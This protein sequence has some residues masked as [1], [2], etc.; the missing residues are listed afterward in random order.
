MSFR[1]TPIGSLKINSLIMIDDEPCKIVSTDKSKPGKH[2]SAKVRVVAIGV[3][4]SVKRSV[5][6]SVD[7]NVNSP[8]VGKKVAQVIS[9]SDTIQ[10]MDSETYEMFETEFPSDKELKNKIVEGADIE[11]WEIAGKTKLMRVR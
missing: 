5:V 3:F 10:L 2:G 11:Y 1:I 8:I 4:D 6:N 9:L 7:T